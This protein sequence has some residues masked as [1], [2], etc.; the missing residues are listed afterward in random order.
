MDNINNTLCFF[1]SVSLWY[2]DLRS[3][4]EMDRFTFEEKQKSAKK[5]FLSKMC[6]ESWDDGGESIGIIS[7]SVDVNNF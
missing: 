3:N 7:N 2:Y 6:A 4:T 5:H 1:L